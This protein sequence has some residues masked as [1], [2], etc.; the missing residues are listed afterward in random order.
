MVR[1]PTPLKQEDFKYPDQ[2][3]LRLPQLVLGIHIPQARFESDF[4]PVA[5]RFKP[6]RKW[7]KIAHETAGEG[8]HVAFWNATLLTL[9][10]GLQDGVDR[11][12][13]NWHGSSVGVGGVRLCELRSYNDDLK[14][15]FEVECDLSWPL[16]ATGQYPI[17]T[18]HLDAMVNVPPDI[19]AG[20]LDDLIDFDSGQDRAR[21]SLGRWSLAILARNS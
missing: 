6:G 7:L 13:R 20:H 9:R 12:L 18:D 1:R 4:P 2:L 15:L 3:G 8:K 17:D 19:R 14:R 11:L 21:A 16:F 10:P 5:Y